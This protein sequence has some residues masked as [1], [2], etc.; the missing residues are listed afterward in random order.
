[1]TNDFKIYVLKNI[2]TR[3]L[4]NA[5]KA[6]RDPRYKLTAD[7]HWNRY[8]NYEGCPDF[9]KYS[10]YEVDMRIKI[11]V[12]KFAFWNPYKGHGCDCYFTAYEVK[13]E[14]NNREHINR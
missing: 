10:D 7:K 13:K 14:L 2:P 12:P 8:D 3:L 5:F 1:M 4:L 6:Q 11:V 9:V